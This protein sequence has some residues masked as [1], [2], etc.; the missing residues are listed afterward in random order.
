MIGK[1]GKE[2]VAQVCNI[3]YMTP[4]VAIRDTAKR[5]GYTAKEGEKISKLFVENTWEKCLEANPTI[6]KDNKEHNELLRIASHLSGRAR[7]LSTHAGGVV[8]GQT[9]LDNYIAIDRGSN[10][11]QVISIN[12]KH[13]EPLGLIKF[14][15]LGLSNL[16]VITETLQLANV[17]E[18]EIDINNPEFANDKKTFDLICSNKVN[19]VFQLEN[20]E[21]QKLIQ[22]I[23]PRKLEDI[24]DITSLIRPDCAPYREPYV[25]YR[26]NNT[27]PEYIHDDMKKIS[28]DTFGQ[29]LY[30]E[31][32]M[33]IV[34]TF[35]GR[36]MGGADIFRKAIGAKDTELVQREVEKLYGEI[37][38]NG[39]PQQVAE[40]LRD[41]LAKAGGYGFNKCLSAD[42]II[43]R[44][45]KNNSKPLSVEEMFKIKNDIEYAKKTKHLDLHNKYN[46]HGYGYGVSMQHRSV[47]KKNKI[48][49]IYDSGIQDVYKITLEGGLSIKC[50]QN[51]K[52]PVPVG[53]RKMGDLMVGDML[54]IK[55]SNISLVDDN[56]YFATLRKI[57]NIEYVG[58]EHTYD[59]EME[60]PYHNLTVN[61][62]I[63]TSNSHAMAYS[64]ISMQ[65]AYLKA[66]YPLEFFTALLRESMNKNDYNALSKHISDA[67]ENFGIKVLPP[68]INKS[69]R[70]FVYDKENNS[71]LF[72]FSAIKGLSN[73]AIDIILENQPFKNMQEVTNYITTDKPIVLLIK[74]GAIPTKNKKR[75]LESYCI[76]KTKKDTKEFKP[77]K[78]AFSVAKAYEKY[79]LD[80]LEIKDK[81]ER[82]RLT[83][84]EK[85]KEYEQ[86]KA[87][88]AERELNKFKDKH[89]Q[90]EY[91]WEFDT[92][93]M[94]IT[95]DP[96]KEAYKYIK[97]SWDKMQ[98]EEENVLLGVVTSVKKKKDRWGN[99]YGDI[100]LYTPFGIIQA[101]CWANAFSEFEPIIK[102]GNALAMWCK[103]DD[104]QAFISHCTPYQ[105][106]LDY[107]KN[108]NKE[109]ESD[110]YY[111]YE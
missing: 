15:I 55:D 37:L 16:N 8:I 28:S 106:W 9:S 70:E 52:F 96:L 11:E 22:Q 104:N 90:N 71:I 85:K 35:G 105:K 24:A 68:H 47:V 93:S 13:C 2:N 54:Y 76:Q 65:I 34:T 42:T 57:K 95:H 17:D 74:S 41:S 82:L 31:Q 39:Y 45:G 72:G 18:H 25:E 21:T 89:L 109:E 61:G 59:V 102:K 62:G 56:I 26:T 78:T 48:V 5:L 12:K 67:R 100:V 27:E 29:I 3:S 19:A 36:S 69:K 14:D 110:V 44:V 51:H 10:G 49:D 83:N 20:S 97:F 40:Y 111:E 66:H 60:D 38:D 23:Q 32:T 88:K 33:S 43:D 80:F 86:K 46:N 79:G 94:F 103:K 63:I 75:M 58:E 108:R 107:Q 1:Y 81:E 84:I 6:I 30:Q 101:K 50:T 98:N 87:T 53:E 99:Q 64:V 4:L 73:D 91:M 77:V 7:N 92:L